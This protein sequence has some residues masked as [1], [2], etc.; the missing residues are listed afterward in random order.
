MVDTTNNLLIVSAVV[1]LIAV[2]LTAAYMSG[3]LNPVIEKIGEYVF[4]TE[5]KAEEKKLEARGLKEGQDFLKGK[6][7]LD[8]EFG[9]LPIVWNR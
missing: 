4:K 3:A 5:A 8:S 6:L 7:C 2:A 1:A 9:L